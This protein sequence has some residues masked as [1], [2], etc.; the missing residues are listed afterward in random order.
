MRIRVPRA[1]PKALGLAMV[2]NEGIREDS[3]EKLFDD[4]IRR[5]FGKLISRLAENG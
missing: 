5:R 4:E 1:S 3:I 2:H